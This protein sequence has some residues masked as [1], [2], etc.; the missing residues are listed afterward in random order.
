MRRAHLAALFLAA[1]AMTGC[2]PKMIPNSEIEDTDENREILSVVSAYKNALEGRNVER[3]MSLVS[4]TF[5]ENSG[6]PAGDDDYNYDGLEQRLT[7]WAEQT[8]AIRADVKVKAITV[9]DGTARAQYFYDVNYQIPGAAG[10][11]QWKHEADTKEMVLRREGSVW[12]I[13]SGI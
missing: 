10:V 13:T 4:K 5:F 11:M 1:V 3:L 9:K 6:T 2:G 8:K 12:R 7:K